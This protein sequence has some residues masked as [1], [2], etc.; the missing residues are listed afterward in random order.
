M[1][2]FFRAVLLY[3]LCIF[4]VRMMGKRQLGDL[5][6][7]EIV[8]TILISNIAS[9]PIEDPSIS[10]M[11]AVIPIIT[12]AAIEVVGSE[13]SLKSRGFR[14][15]VSGRP[16]VIIKEGKIDQQAMRELR[17]T[18]DDLMENL[19]GEGV[20]DLKDVWHCVVETNGKVNVLERYAARTLTPA[21]MHIKEK[22]I[23]PPITVITDGELLP[24]A[25][26][27]YGISQKWLEGVLKS[28][29][30]RV[31]EVYLMTVDGGGNYFIV[32]K[33]EG[34]K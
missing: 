7:S 30:K 21:D 32:D 2:V 1:N 12:L 20:F 23:L 27:F 9:L 26:D 18:L 5:Q 6:P 3:I 13:I 25:M 19:R 11:A 15:L 34:N 8:T 29:G 14:L 16:R 17:I 10:M 24:G 28:K 22:D 31:E 33:A 4:A